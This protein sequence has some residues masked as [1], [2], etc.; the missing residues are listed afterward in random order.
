M[1]GIGRINEFRTRVL[2]KIQHSE[3]LLQQLSSNKSI[4]IRGETR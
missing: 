4:I 2:I 3:L 1:F